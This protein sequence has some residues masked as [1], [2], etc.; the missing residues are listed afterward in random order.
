MS[1]RLRAAVMLTAAIDLVLGLLFLFAPELGFTLWPTA[2]SP[3]L[4]R[5]I[6]AIVIGNGL[7]AWLVARQGTWEGARALFTVALVYGVVTLVS[8][9]YHLVLASPPAAPVFWIYA[10]ATAV[11]LVPIAI[12]YWSYERQRLGDSI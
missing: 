9:V 4:S 7:G 3:L 8:V 1:S 12:T 11:F 2:V 5:F 6:G 10:I